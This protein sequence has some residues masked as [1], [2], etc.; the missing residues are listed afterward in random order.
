MDQHPAS[1]DDGHAD[2]D[3]RGPIARRGKIEYVVGKHRKLLESFKSR[4]SETIQRNI[5]E[6]F[7]DSRRT[8][9]KSIPK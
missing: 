1:S 7:A 8:L 2:Y 9:H 6:Y 5:E 3:P 4:D